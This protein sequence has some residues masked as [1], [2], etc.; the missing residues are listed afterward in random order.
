MYQVGQ[1]C[2][3]CPENSVCSRNYPGLCT[4]QGEAGL[5]AK[6]EISSEIFTTN[7][8]NNEMIIRPD[9]GM[10]NQYPQENFNENEE[11]SILEKRWRDDFN[12]QYHQKN[13]DRNSFRQMANPENKQIM[14]STNDNLNDQYPQEDLNE[15]MQLSSSERQRRN[16]FYKQYHQ[17]K[18]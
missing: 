15:N 8:E 10:N 5:S 7:L 18:H 3:N 4:I 6:P 11:F 2:S 12:K 9:D 16:E 13:I 14:L 1:P 17:K